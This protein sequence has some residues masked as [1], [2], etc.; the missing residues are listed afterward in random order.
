MLFVIIFYLFKFF[1]LFYY[2][3]IILFPIQGRLSQDEIEKMIAD[4]KKY[5]AEDE[6]HEKKIKAKNGLESYVYNI[7]NQCEDEKLKGKLIDEDKK[8]LLDKVGEIQEWLD[9]N[10]AAEVEELE[11]KQKEVEAVANPIMSKLYHSIAPPGAQGAP[12]AGANHDS[13]TQDDDLDDLD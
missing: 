13:A 8:T 12:G 7:K 6:A 4:A 2:S 9:A 1:E 3:R 10:Q 5:K 11:A